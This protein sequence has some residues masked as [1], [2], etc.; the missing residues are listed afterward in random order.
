MM[1]YFPNADRLKE[2]MNEWMNRDH[3]CII[4]HTVPCGPLATKVAASFF[5][6][7]AFKNKIL[8]MAFPPSTGNKRTEKE[9][10]LIW[11]HKFKELFW[12]WRWPQA[13]RGNLTFCN[14]DKIT[15][16]YDLARKSPRSLWKHGVN[17]C[18]R[19][20]GLKSDSRWLSTKKQ[21]RC[22]YFSV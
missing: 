7:L 6:A 5:M 19:R 12:G 11:K 8:P 14:L 21:R 18:G 4:L 9:A 13:T 16:T 1:K 10:S 17:V 3:W 2:W 20:Y 22:N 15:S